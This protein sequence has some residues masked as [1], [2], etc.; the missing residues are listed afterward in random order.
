MGQE[1]GSVEDIGQGWRKAEKA[2]AKS[3]QGG[4]VFCG[5]TVCNGG[6]ENG[7]AVLPRALWAKQV[8][9]RCVMDSLQAQCWKQHCKGLH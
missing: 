9:S 4:R 1:T 7:V 3:T 6:L 8:Q 5:V 2:R